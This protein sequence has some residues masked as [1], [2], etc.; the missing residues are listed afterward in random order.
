MAFQT[1]ISTKPVR[2][3]I[4]TFDAEMETP[5]DELHYLYLKAPP[6]LV[7]IASSRVVPEFGRPYL[8]PVSED[9]SAFAAV[10]ASCHAIYFYINPK[11]PYVEQSSETRHGVESILSILQAASPRSG[12]EELFDSMVKRRELFEDCSAQKVFP[13]SWGVRLIPKDPPVLDQSTLTRARNEIIPYLD[14]TPPS[15]PSVAIAFD[16]LAAI[17]NLE[18][19]WL[20][21]NKRLDDEGDSA[22]VYEQ[23]KDEFGRKYDPDFDLP[24]D[25]PILEFDFEAWETKVNQARDVFLESFFRWTEENEVTVD[26][27]STVGIKRC[28]MVL[29]ELFAYCYQNE[30]GEI[31][32]IKEVK[33]Q[34]LRVFVLEHLL[35]TVF[36]EPADYLFWVP[37]VRLFFRYLG[38]IKYRR[39]NS[40]TESL[41]RDIE[42]EMRRYIMQQYGGAN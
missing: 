33:R 32:K 5:E 24:L 7:P 27:R 16:G 41:F 20:D 12:A 31:L 25:L 14:R 28:R 8:T 21:E 38:E 17:E 26:G 39:W 1:K 36:Q 15:R 35:V 22:E 9:S 6:G 29:E 11:S 2:S 13:F 4:I 37:L 19:F 30:T 23:F 42:G 10:L 34:D 18:R 3:E 40:K